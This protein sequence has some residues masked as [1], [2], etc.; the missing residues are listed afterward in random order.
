MYGDPLGNV[1]SRPSRSRALK[2]NGR[3]DD[4]MF[5]RLD[6]TRKLYGRRASIRYD[7][8]AVEFLRNPVL[9]QDC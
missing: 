2:E 6:T 8:T 5:V 3:K 9:Q 1:V 4:D 7:H